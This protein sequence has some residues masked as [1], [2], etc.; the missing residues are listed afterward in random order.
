MNL[1]L[2]GQKQRVSLARVAYSQPDVALFDDPLSALDAETVSV[3]FY[4]PSIL[5]QDFITLTKR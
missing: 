4:T 1:L 3:Y 2:V 5:H